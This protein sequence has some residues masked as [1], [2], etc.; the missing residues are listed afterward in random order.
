MTRYD[1]M[2]LLDFTHHW[3]DEM[4]YKYFELTPE[5]IETIENEMT[6]K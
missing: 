2:P 5:E 1:F 6:A 3:T 4:L